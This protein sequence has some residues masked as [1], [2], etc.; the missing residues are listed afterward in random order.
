M[1]N[2]LVASSDVNCRKGNSLNSFSFFCVRGLN[3]FS[4]HF[5]QIRASAT[6]AISS[7]THRVSEPIPS[8]R[9][10]RLDIPAQQSCALRSTNRKST[11]I[12]QF[13]RVMSLKWSAQLT[14]DFWKDIFGEQPRSASSRH[15]TPKRCNS[16]RRPSPTYRRHRQ[17]RPSPTPLTTII[18]RPSS[19]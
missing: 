18:N 4:I 9:P 6:R 10:A 14:A 7:A 3:R 8:Q 13:N 19:A 5:K 2:R 17:T 15:A 12:L 11:D 1:I 16:V